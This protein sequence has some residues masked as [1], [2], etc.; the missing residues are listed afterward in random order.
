[1]PAYYINCRNPVNLF[2]PPFARALL[3]G[4]EHNGRREQVAQISAQVA[5]LTERA[6]Q[7]QRQVQQLSWQLIQVQ[8]ALEELY[9]Q[10]A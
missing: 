10:M 5:E 9:V 1:M 2:A 3:S 8:R 7:L 4:G 6:E